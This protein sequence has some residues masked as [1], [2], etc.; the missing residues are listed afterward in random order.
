MD[1]N[2]LF[3]LKSILQGAL[4]KKCPRPLA[5]LASK[6]G[7]EGKGTEAVVDFERLWAQ[8]IDDMIP[9]VGP[10]A[11]AIMS[12][13]W[14][15]IDKNKLTD[16]LG[17]WKVWTQHRHDLEEAARQLNP[18]AKGGRGIDPQV[19]RAAQK[20]LQGY[21]AFR[22]AIA[23]TEEREKKG[24]FAR[25][26]DWLTGKTTDLKQTIQDFDLDEWAESGIGQ[27]ATGAAG[28]GMVAAMS[29]RGD[30][31]GYQEERQL[32]A[33]ERFR[34]WAG[35]ESQYPSLT[36][37]ETLAPKSVTK[38]GYGTVIGHLPDGRVVLE[39]AVSLWVV[40]PGE[41]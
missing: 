14:S 6:S 16:V 40:D 15:G 31:E 13:D 4:G 25:F 30:V 22:S 10:G 28:A 11:T 29:Y 26:K 9:A 34:T 41:L 17:V 38:L 5:D 3:N 37:L 39:T 21:N 24:M 32:P 19:A 12:G 33:R 8:F 20:Q 18:F 7:L 36:K 23:P 27:V 35:I 2:N 1:I